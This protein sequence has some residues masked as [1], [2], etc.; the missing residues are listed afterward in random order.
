LSSVRRTLTAA[1]M[2]GRDLARRALALLLLVALPVVF[3]VVSRA[4][5]GGHA[6]TAGGLGL[7]W[8]IA[9]ASL[10]TALGARSVDQ[11]LVLDGYRP[12]E[13]LA[14]HLLLLDAAGVGLSAGFAAL[15][16]AVSGTPDLGALVLALVLVALIAVPLGL[17]LAVLV[18]HELEATLLLIGLIGIEMILP[19]GSATA[20]ALPLGGPQALLDR[21]AGKAHP[22]AVAAALGRSVLWIV[23]LTIVGALI[24]GW[25]T[26]VHR[27]DAPTPRAVRTR[28]QSLGPSAP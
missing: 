11:R 22:A 6:F 9:G 17:V 26:R 16:V 14:A 20:G 28:G 27:P 4:S 7:S 1:E 15:L 10:F 23:A 8:A 24:W 5:E 18:P 19:S 3:F 21:A 2:F 25:R 13:L 12:V